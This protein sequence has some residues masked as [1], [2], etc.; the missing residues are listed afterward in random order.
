MLWIQSWTQKDVFLRL[1][2][3]RRG[4]PTGATS[5]TMRMTHGRGIATSHRVLWPMT[6]AVAT[7]VPE[8]EETEE[9]EE[10][11]KDHEARMIAMARGRGVAA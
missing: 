10:T 6:V 1:T 9:T 8:T 2:A 11:V 3:S 4:T 7:V 5:P